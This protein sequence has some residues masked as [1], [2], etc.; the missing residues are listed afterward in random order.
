MLAN[1]YQLNAHRSA[2][3]PSEMAIEYIALGLASEAGEVAGKVKKGIRDG[4]HWS[5][6]QRE[7]HRRSL[8]SELSDVL[9]YSAELCTVL[10]VT[11]Q[12][13]MQYNLD[14]LAD[15]QRRGVL[16]GSGDAR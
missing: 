10:G 3:Y 13:V 7:D 14:K 1:E 8:L 2:I 5:G 9:W 16:G 4:K 11:L 6:E 15:R 12:D